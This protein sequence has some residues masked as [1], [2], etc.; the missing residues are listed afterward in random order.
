MY[1]WTKLPHVASVKDSSSFSYVNRIV[2]RLNKLL[3]DSSKFESLS[4]L[5]RLKQQEAID[6]RNAII[7]KLDLIKTKTRVLK[8][9]VIY[10]N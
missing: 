1:G 6:G 7:P 4:R 3:S 2:T 5:S 9:E 8:K 10:R